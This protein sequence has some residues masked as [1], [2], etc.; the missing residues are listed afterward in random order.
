MIFL[1][2]FPA[3]AVEAA[4]TA[5]GSKPSLKNAVA[6]AVNEASLGS[7]RSMDNTAMATL[8]EL[9]KYTS[10]DRP[11]VIVSTDLAKRTWFLN[12]RI[13]RYYEP[14]RDIW[15]LNDQA[16][17]RTALKVR[18]FSSLR[19]ILADVTPITVPIGARLLWIIEPG[20]AFEADLAET[21]PVSGGRYVLYTDL[22]RNAAPF[23][24]A[25]FEFKPQ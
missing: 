9:R 8:K 17:V 25:G 11:T 13:L 5:T 12:W 21:I 18:R 22:P 3:P 20:S 19:S 23:V 14:L 7:I 6:F 15:V 10:T 24:V 2:F 16:A 4:A 1:N